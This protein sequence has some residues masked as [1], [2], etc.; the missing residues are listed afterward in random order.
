MAGPSTQ[1]ATRLTQSGHRLTAQRMLVADSLSRARRALS[2]QEL[3]HRLLPGH[4]YLG[5]ATVFRTLDFLVDAGLAQRF[6][7]EGHVYLYAAC[8]PHH[9]HHLV[10]RTCGAITDIDDVAVR[11]LISTVRTRY[12]FDLDHDALDFYGTCSR[13]SR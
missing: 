11:T 9:H 2:A 8:E 10:C 3:Y 1:I 4:P 5:R 12:A 6:E 13:C 7:G